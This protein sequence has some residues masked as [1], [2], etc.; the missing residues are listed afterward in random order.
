MAGKRLLFSATSS[1]AAILPANPFLYLF[2]GADAVRLV[3]LRWREG[4]KAQIAQ[5]TGQA[6]TGAV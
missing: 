6:Y 1:A 4:I 3:T 2:E 5:I